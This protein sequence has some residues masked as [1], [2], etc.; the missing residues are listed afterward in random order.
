MSCVGGTLRTIDLTRRCSNRR[1]RRRRNDMV[2]R[3]S[4]KLETDME[5]QDG[6]RHELGRFKDHD[7]RI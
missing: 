5:H 1:A 2:V 6:R 7:V 3:L 4:L